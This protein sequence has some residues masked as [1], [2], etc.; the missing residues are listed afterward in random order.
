MAF[1]CLCAVSVNVKTKSKL[2]GWFEFEWMRM[3]EWMKCMESKWILQWNFDET[4][5]K[6]S[7]L[8][9]TFSALMSTANCLLHS[10]R[11]ISYQSIERKRTHIRILLPVV[12][13]CLDYSWAF[14]CWV[15]LNWFITWHFDC[16]VNSSSNRKFGSNIRLGQNVIIN[17]WQKIIYRKG[18]FEG[19]FIFFFAG[20]FSNVILQSK[21]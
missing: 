19:N 17:K 4:L 16:A 9:T 1:A 5:I 14:Q 10:K 3:G 8:W 18:N 13:V 11:A 20:D 12:E 7:L 6:C 15:S 2:S 21:A